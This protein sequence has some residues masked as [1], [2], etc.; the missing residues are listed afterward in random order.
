MKVNGE[1]WVR[2]GV[3]APEG[4]ESRTKKADAKSADLNV[5][6]QRWLRTGIPPASSG[7]CRYG[8]F[9]NA[10]DYLACVL[11]INEAREEFLRLPAQVRKRCDNNPGRFLELVLNPETRGELLELG[12][13]EQA[14]PEAAKEVESAPET[15]ETPEVPA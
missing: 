4:G 8:D 13:R 15:P 1:E 14:L 6:V 3:V 7:V 11:R 12:L 5:M 2:S 10:D 9:S